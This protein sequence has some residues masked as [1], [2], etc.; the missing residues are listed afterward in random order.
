M[1]VERP[2]GVNVT[3]TEFEI[4]T[5]IPGLKMTAWNP[6][7]VLVQ[8]VSDPLSSSVSPS[9]KARYDVL[10]GLRRCDSPEDETQ[11]VN[12]CRSKTPPNRNPWLR[13]DFRLPSSPM[14]SAL[15]P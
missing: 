13:S 5:M 4:P 15:T 1:R 12:P 14:K 3:S 10:S 9:A 2:Y 6:M 11:F 8:R 7:A